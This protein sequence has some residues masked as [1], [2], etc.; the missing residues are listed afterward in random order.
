MFTELFDLAKKERGDLELM[1]DEIMRESSDIKDRRIIEL[2]IDALDIVLS[3]C[4]EIQ[5]THPRKNWS[6]SR[7]LEDRL[8]LVSLSYTQDWYEDNPIFTKYLPTL[9]K[10]REWI[11]RA[12]VDWKYPH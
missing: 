2:E 9:L 11:D 7:E 4:W 10:I 6:R 3:C 5:R 12:Y 1:R 8:Q